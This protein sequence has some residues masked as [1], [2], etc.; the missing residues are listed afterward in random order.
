MFI[1][2]R[3]IP[4]IPKMSSFGIFGICGGDA[5][6]PVRLNRRRSLPPRQLRGLN[7]FRRAYQNASP[8]SPPNFQ[9][10]TSRGVSLFF[11]ILRAYAERHGSPKIPKLVQL[12]NVSEFLCLWRGGRRPSLRHKSWGLLVK[13][14]STSRSRSSE[15]NASQQVPK[16]FATDGTPGRPSSLQ[17][18]AELVGSRGRCHPGGELRSELS[19]GAAGDGRRGEVLQNMLFVGCFGL[20]YL[21]EQYTDLGFPSSTVFCSE[22]RTHVGEG[23]SEV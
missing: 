21:I 20:Q 17:G 12:G 9:E 3:E 14:R 4:K 18:I 15:Y 1:H 13:L 8:Q 22:A 11:G 5:S 7:R 23:G 19:L 6:G 10:I 2:Q 16:S